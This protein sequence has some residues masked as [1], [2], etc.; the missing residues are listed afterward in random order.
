M[1]A[2]SRRAP[3]VLQIQYNA[4]YSKS[5]GADIYSIILLRFISKI[6]GRQ[7]GG[8]RSSRTA[9]MWP[10]KRVYGNI[11]SRRSLDPS[12][13]PNQPLALYQSWCLN[14]TGWQDIGE[15]EAPRSP[16][17]T[18]IHKLWD[19]LQK[20]AWQVATLF[21]SFTPPGSSPNPKPRSLGIPWSPTPR[22]SREWV[23]PIRLNVRLCLARRTN[24]K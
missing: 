2:N 19:L 1:S 5:S 21:H 18:K 8:W 7:G 15:R 10:R 24:D 4:R 13:C 14:L 16:T 6:Q 23:Q 11:I 17:V 12:S 9:A 22:E 20:R 3:W